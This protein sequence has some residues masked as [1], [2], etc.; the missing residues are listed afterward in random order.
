LPRLAA[1]ALT[2][3]LLLAA[4]LVPGAAVSSRAHAC[5][6][7]PFDVALR[8]ESSGTIVIAT[9]ASVSTTAARFTPEAFLKGPVTAGDLVLTNPDR[10]STCTPA[11][12][13]E[14]GRVVLFLSTNRWPDSGSVLHLVDGE[15]RWLGDAYTVPEQQLVDDIR[16]I[17]E[18]YAVP[19][20]S[21]SESQGIEWWKT[22]VPVG[23]AVLGI[24][25]VGLFLMRIW[26]RIDPS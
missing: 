22:V 14:G 7:A 2:L 16:T 25:I 24:F 1:N 21:S 18:Q 19:P 10:N 4:A 17:T 12:F 13:V 20:A 8:T 6:Y 23:G 9:T 3:V 26:H 15:A 5:S 11:D